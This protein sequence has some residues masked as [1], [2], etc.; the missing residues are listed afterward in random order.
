MVVS[1]ARPDRR[2]AGA[3]AAGASGRPVFHVGAGG[4]ERSVCARARGASLLVAPSSLALS[5]C[6]QPAPRGARR[7]AAVGMHPSS[8]RQELL[9]S[10]PPPTAEEEDDPD[11]R[12]DEAGVPTPRS[13]GGT[14]GLAP[15]AAV[16][17]MSALYVVDG[18][19]APTRT[20]G[21]VGSGEVGGEG[22]AS[23]A[24]ESRASSN[25][26]IGGD[27]GS[28][29][30]A[31]AGGRA[32]GA[33]GVCYGCGIL[34]R[35][36]CGRLGEGVAA[37][38]ARRWA[39]YR[40]DWADGAGTPGR[41]YRLLAP[42]TYIF[43][44][45]FMPAIAFGE[46]LNENTRGAFS[47]PHVLIADAIGGV[48]QSVIGGQPLLIVGVAQPMVLIYSF[49]FDY[50][51]SAGDADVFRPTMSYVL[52]FA[53]ALH[54]LVAL[55]NACGLVAYFTRFSGETFGALIA[56]LFVQDSIKGLVRE[57]QGDGVVFDPSAGVDADTQSAWRLING[58]WSLFL[59]GTQVL[60]S[61]AALGATSWRTL[62]GPAR[63]ALAAYGPPLAVVC[64]TGLSY[65]V[66]GAPGGAQVPT[67]VDAEQVY[68][69]GV[70]ESWSTITRLGEVEGKV[71]GRASSLGGARC[72]EACALLLASTSY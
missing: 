26:A 27:G 16:V 31:V 13:E 12:D 8:S 24:D 53:A 33:W 21:F 45:S 41:L 52:L 37:D 36:T 1:C 9:G 5:P 69:D 4:V 29:D 39:W 51:D 62:R 58:L 56:V 40:Q 66:G 59:A 38:A 6:P 32:G 70:R 2:A 67:R 68:A 47:V 55:L 14:P 30:G 28:Q 11:G 25:P 17:E 42:S 23:V 10:I 64:V 46:Q 35:A 34:A 19:V 7:V 49:V 63:R 22:G 72:C 61:I 48:A 65:A 57:F 3:V 54:A 50:L 60:V 44:A 71:R 18:E 20:P 15:P 43:L